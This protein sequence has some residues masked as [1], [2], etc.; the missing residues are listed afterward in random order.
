MRRFRSPAAIALVL[1]LAIVAVGCDGC[2]SVAPGNDPIL[3]RAEQTYNITLDSLDTLFNLQ[4]DN[5]AAIEKLLPGTN[6]IVNKMRADAKIALPEL[7]KAID[8][9]RTNKDAAAL[10]KWSAVATRL[11]ASAMSIMAKIS[12]S[13]AVPAKLSA[14]PAWLVLQAA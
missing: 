13:N 11:L 9:Y 4:M 2:S 10:Q 3:V 8:T 12:E 7:R 1:A 5:A 14:A 6:A